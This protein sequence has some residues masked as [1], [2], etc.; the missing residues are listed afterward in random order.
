M[1]VGLLKFFFALLDILNTKDPNPGPAPGSIEDEVFRCS[2][3][4]VE[5]FWSDVDGDLAIACTCSCVQPAL[6]VLLVSPPPIPSSF[7]L[8]LRGPLSAHLWRS[9]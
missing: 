2:E 5:V 3:V 6:G 7:V 9:G 1:Y 4:V 8:I